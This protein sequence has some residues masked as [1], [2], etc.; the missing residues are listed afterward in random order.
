MRIIIEADAITAPKMSG[1]GHATLEIIRALG[2]KAKLTGDT[3][4]VV[5]PYGLKPRIKKYNLPAH[6]VVRQLP[7]LYKYVNYALTR[8]NLPLPV[9][10][11]YGRGVYI[12]PN[13]KTWYVPFSKAI[14]FVH[15][16]AFKIMPEVTHQKNLIYLEANFSRWLKRAD[17]I[18]AIS[19]QT[20]HD[21]HTFFPEYAHKLNRIYLGVNKGMYFPQSQESLC[22]VTKKYGLK[23]DYFLYIGNIEPRKNLLVL[24]DAYKLYCDRYGR[25]IQLVLIGGDG[26]KNQEV[27]RRI[28][29]L[30]VAGYDV[31]RP[32]HYVGDEDLPAIYSGARALI[33]V[34]LYEGY[35]LSL[36][37]AQSCGTPIIA[38]NLPVFKETL[39]DAGV[40]YVST[41]STVDE[42]V[43]AMA[44]VDDLRKE[45][46]PTPRHTWDQTAQALLKLSLSRQV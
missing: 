30:K 40:A 43:S 28:R 13:Y 33:H 46:D 42:V 23:R 16:V 25:T 32:S 11:L 38:T 31:I 27:L 41:T 18:V 36:I 21:V 5:V 44:T 35:G 26:W 12:F 20:M 3:I 17:A 45:V 8:T 39:N 22:A 4:V 15:D 34:A 29:E 24:L 6:I 19:N 2:E 10:L 1:I 9:D 37:Q 7:P 14:T